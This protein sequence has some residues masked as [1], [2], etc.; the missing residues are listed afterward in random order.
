MLKINEK[1]YWPLAERA[2]RAYTRNVIRGFFSEDDI[3]QL[4]IDVATRI[5]EKRDRYDESLGTVSAW[6]GKIAKNIVLDT[7]KSEKRRRSLFSSAP[8]VERVDEDGDPVGFV[9]VAAD[10][11]DAQA[12][13]HDTERFLRSSVKSDRQKRLFNGLA[14][15]LDSA[16]LAEIEGVEPSKIYT[17]VSRLR[18]VLRKSY[19]S[20][21]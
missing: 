8:V 6:V 19:G 12:I 10:E 18:S 20:T 1:D 3:M 4:I 17:P 2:V 15:G 13:A 14:G 5:W 21:A 11:T 9:P 7:V 16:E